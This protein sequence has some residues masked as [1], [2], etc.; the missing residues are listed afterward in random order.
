MQISDYSEINVCLKMDGGICK[1][2]ILCVCMYICIVMSI[3]V[4]AS[5]IRVLVY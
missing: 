5:L 4:Q 1:F 2:K 3:S